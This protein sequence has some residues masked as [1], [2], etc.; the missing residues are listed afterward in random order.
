MNWCKSSL[1]KAIAVLVL[2][3]GSLPAAPK[4]VVFLVLDQLF[5]GRLGLYGNPR[6]TSPHID[7]I[8]RQGAVFRNHHSCAPWTAA[9]VG[10]IY[11][12][13][14]PNQDKTSL[15]QL[16]P[17]DAN[18]LGP[19]TTMPELFQKGGF[20]TS[21]FITNVVAG[22]YLTRKG[23]DHHTV[24]GPRQENSTPEVIFT[25]V[26]NLLKADPAKKQFVYVHLWEPHSPYEPA[27]GYDRYKG[28]LYDDIDTAGVGL[29]S[30]NELLL[31][32]Q[33]NLGD[34][35][36]IERLQGLYDGQIAQ[37]DQAVGDFFDELQKAFAK[38]DLLLVLTSDH[39]ELLYLR[40]HYYMT[41]DH[42][43]L[44]EPVLHVPLIFYGSG[45]P[46]GVSI[47]MP[48]SHIDTAST[49]L[50]LAGTGVSG[51]NSGHSLA[52][53]FD[54]GQ[55]EEPVLFAEQD[56]Y[57]RLR[58]VSFQGHKLIR[59]LDSGED[60]LFDLRKDPDE[61]IDIKND[62]PKMYETMKG[63]MD[64]KT[65][66]FE[67][68]EA[69]LQ[70]A[71]KVPRTELIVDNDAQGFMFNLKGT[72][73][74]LL[75]CDECT[76]GGAYATTV[77]AGKVDP[78]QVEWRPFNPLVG[79]YRVFYHFPPVIQDL[80]GPFATVQLDIHTRGA[81]VQTMRVTGPGST[82]WL[83]LGVFTNVWKV[84]LRTDADSNGAV[85]ADSMRFTPLN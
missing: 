16:L 76:L 58:M 36:A 79:K 23:Y 51:Y 8:G 72:P 85:L 13:L 33:A 29:F 1:W 60:L 3:A 67:T 7:A 15:F 38:E 35:S 20:E 18:L 74:R 10:C 4:K 42:C 45:L 84:V 71:G 24:L 27:A 28:T 52:P 47:R 39:G 11:T 65:Q 66:G 21:A 55:H 48:T 26:L 43:T 40:R 80:S 68:T 78:K 17:D 62:K 44:F 32:R 69:W 41:S 73:W 81:E 56:L 64:T 22:A 83:D 70:R 34:T 46:G 25:Q 5:A 9:S 82:E 61:T 63:I 2:T 31:P 14:Y 59:S 19:Y 75:S 30:R 57:E 77:E 37:T 53:L 54:G 12:A 50:D 49:A 6:E